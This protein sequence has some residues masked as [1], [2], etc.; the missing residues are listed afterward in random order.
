MDEPE[1]TDEE[2][3]AR[4]KRA[5]MDSNWRGYGL[6]LAIEFYAHTP[7]TTTQVIDAAKRF[8]HYVRYGDPDEA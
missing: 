7:G 3:E 5:Q 1:I 2:R 6:K 8:E 4:A